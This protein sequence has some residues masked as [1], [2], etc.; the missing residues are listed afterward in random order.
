MIEVRKNVVTEENAMPSTYAHY[1]FGKQVLEQYPAP[2]ADAE[3][4]NRQL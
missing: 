3:R 2:L 4:A 1:K